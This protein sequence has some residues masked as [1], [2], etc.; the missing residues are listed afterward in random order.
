MSAM[1]HGKRA[2]ET[3]R[4]SVRAEDGIK[5]GRWTWTASSGSREAT[6]ANKVPGKV[7]HS[8]ANRPEGKLPPV[9]P[10]KRLW[11]G[12]DRTC[13][14]GC[15]RLWRAWRMTCGDNHFGRLRAFSGYRH[16]GRFAALLRG[17]GWGGMWPKVAA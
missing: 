13:D 6:N 4:A 7:S 8:A 11:T 5:P 14:H 3:L 17:E 15:M 9:W 1:G 16:C 10:A 2:F 12:R